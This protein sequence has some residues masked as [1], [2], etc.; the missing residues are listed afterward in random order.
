MSQ[1]ILPKILSAH[2]VLFVQFPLPGSH[3][4]CV[5]RGWLLLHED[6]SAYTVIYAAYQL[7]GDVQQGRSERVHGFLG[8]EVTAR[9]RL[10]L[11]PRM[12]SHKFSDCLVCSLTKSWLHLEQEVPRCGAWCP[13]RLIT[14]N[15]YSLLSALSLSSPS[16]QDIVIAEWVT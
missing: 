4:W 11:M 8:M 13:E 15:Q 16:S 5:T 12:N 9:L 2:D 1:V 14:F 10:C 3:V 7:G 6:S